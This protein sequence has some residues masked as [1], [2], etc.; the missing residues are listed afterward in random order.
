VGDLDFVKIGVA[1]LPLRLADMA[2]VARRAEDLG[3][4]SV[5]VAV[6]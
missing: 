6:P 3:F 4:A 5:W 1:L 2:P